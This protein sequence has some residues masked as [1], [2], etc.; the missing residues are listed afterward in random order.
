MKQRYIRKIRKDQDMEKTNKYKFKD[1]MKY[2][3]LASIELIAEPIITNLTQD[4]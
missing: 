1:A 2:R 4:Y 3:G